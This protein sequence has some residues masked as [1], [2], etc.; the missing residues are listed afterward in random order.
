MTQVTV[1]ITK[2]EKVEHRKGWA[3]S[4]DHIT[5]TYFVAHKRNSSGIWDVTE[6]KT[7]CSV[8]RDFGTR[9]EAIERTRE[10]LAH[11]TNEYIEQL[12]N[13]IGTPE[14]QPLIKN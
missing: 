7:G 12:I 8:Y 6:P 3:F 13:T 11:M 14:K 4:V 9:K 5:C 2:P 10:N 1:P